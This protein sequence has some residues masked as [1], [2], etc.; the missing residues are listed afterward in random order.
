MTNK[1]DKSNA[2]TGHIATQAAQPKHRSSSNERISSARLAIDV[3]EWFF[4]LKPTP[5]P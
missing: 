3:W 1:L 5:T 2:S 4:L